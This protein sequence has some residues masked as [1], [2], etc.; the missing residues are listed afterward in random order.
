MQLPV[1]SNSLNFGVVSCVFLWAMRKV[2]AVFR[3]AHK[4]IADLDLLKVLQSEINHELSAKTFQVTLFSAQKSLFF[5]VFWVHLMEIMFIFFFVETPFLI[6]C[7]VYAKR[8]TGYFCF[9]LVL[10]KF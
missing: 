6:F 3:Q 4:A 10:F 1:C 7:E 2:P 8:V 5:L 9:D